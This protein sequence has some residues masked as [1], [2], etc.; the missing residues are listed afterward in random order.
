M[1][2]QCEEAGEPLPA[3]GERRVMI[4]SPGER[5]AVVEVVEVS[6]IRLGDADER[7]AS[8]EGEG[9]RS[10]AEWREAHED[11]WRRQ[12]LPEL[13]R[14]RALDDAT[15]VVVERFRVVSRQGRLSRGEP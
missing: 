13:R 5:V 14:P 9:F 2:A 8:D 1:L 4:G 3:A 11:F 15:A 10:V 7:L 6:V 12:V